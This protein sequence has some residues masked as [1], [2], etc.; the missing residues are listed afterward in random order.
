M[1]RRAEIIS[2]DVPQRSVTIKFLY[3][4]FC[5]IVYI[6]G[7]GRDSNLRLALKE[8][9]D[10]RNELEKVFDNYKG[11]SL[12]YKATIFLIKQMPYRY[13]LEG[14]ELDNLYCYYETA[15]RSGLSPQKVADSIQSAG[16]AF[17]KSRLHVVPDI[18]NVSAEFLIDHIDAAFEIWR[19]QPW[20]KNIS[21]DT[22]CHHILPYRV[23][24]EKL[25][26]WLREMHER[27]NPLL[28]SIRSTPDSANIIKVTEALVTELQKI[29]KN[30]GHGLPSGLTIG[31][32]NTKWFAGDCREFTDIQ[33]YIMRAV[34]LPG[35]CDKMPMNGNYFLPHFWNYV[36]DENGETHYCSVLF[37]TPFTEL[38]SDYPGPKG[39]VMREKFE[40]NEEYSER[41]DEYSNVENVHPEFRYFTDEDVTPIY[42]G[43]SIKT[44]VVSLNECYD[45]PKKNEFVYA[46][47]SS[48]LDWVPVDVALRDGNNLVIK[49][50]DG[51][52]VMR[53]G[54]YRDS[55]LQFIS[56][57][58]NIC[59]KDGSIR[60]YNPGTENENVC[61]LYKFDDI[62]RE[63][64][65]IGMLGGVIEGS[66]YPDFREKDTLHIIKNAPS[67]LFTRAKSASDKPYKYVRYY[68]PDGGKCYASEVSFYGHRPGQTKNELL[69][70]ECIGTPNF[71]SDNKY[72]YTNVVD[73]DPYTSFVYEKVSGGWVGLAL[74][75]PM[76]IDSI[77]Y[78][79]RNRRNFIE[80]GDDYELLYCDKEWKSLGRK[81]AVS[82]SIIFNA[83]VG[84]LLYLKNYSR[85]NQ[86]R[87]F[88]YTNGKQI[89]W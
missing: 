40:L 6:S 28:D 42:S 64:F 60:F 85:G 48:H 83:P 77:V 32:D 11:D 41:L 37:K 89:F 56:N 22:F 43:D 59:K 76:V 45:T 20:G 17:V 30:Y 69:K 67:R 74:P 52:V 46:C 82:D 27:F 81:R 49:D 54:V 53:L 21:F 15:S 80:A 55:K 57:P 87:I 26:P 25:R 71:H 23:G 66:D 88:E 78:T 18:R 34:G 1:K 13:G 16:I 70:G 50:V 24:N 35:G 75:S 51:D 86:E 19:T 8:A 10:N 62:F 36:I 12:K 58:F 65:S 63:K 33:T 3:F 84:A 7:C 79:P 31:P 72:P 44:A 29:R 2:I 38:A 61:L 9:E 5:L 39:K 14:E 4:L 47:L 68:G 73:G